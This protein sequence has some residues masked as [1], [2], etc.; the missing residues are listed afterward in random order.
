MKQDLPDKLV[1]KTAFSAPVPR[2]TSRARETYQHVKKRF[3]H[4]ETATADAIPDTLERS[5]KSVLNAATWDAL[6]EQTFD[7]LDRSYSNWFE[8]ASAQ[9]KVR[10]CLSLSSA[11]PDM[12]LRWATAR[13]VPILDP[14]D[15]SA[16]SNA[17]VL[18]SMDGL[19]ER[20]P[21]G[22][23]RLRAFCSELNASDAKILLCGTTVQWTWLAMVA[24]IDLISADCLMLPPY[25]AHHL[26]A[27]I[28]KSKPER[29]LK[30]RVSGEDIL[31]TEDD[32]LSDAYLQD[33]AAEVRGCPWAALSVLDHA[34]TRQPDDQ[35][36]A[37]W[38]GRPE[39]PILP[40]DYARIA[41]F[42]LHT[43]LLYGSVPVGHLPD[44]V[45]RPLPP[46]LPHVLERLG[47]MQIDR[48]GLC[49]ITRHTVAHTRRDLL[50]A[51]FPMDDV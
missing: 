44:A 12:F 38:V 4:R 48:D 33:L 19:I 7:L 29:V 35:G 18:P 15:V 14:D 9:L 25:Q 2:P 13:K 27:L 17:A 8:D 16:A 28:H 24:S 36:D 31:K 43:L 1:T 5:S 37:V 40:G 22:L 46:G 10:T 34:M 45:G 47:F 26:G 6:E 32:A 30:S 42:V 50:D 49:R 21:E 41:R 20:S 51:G 39:W 3:L 11:P 23:E